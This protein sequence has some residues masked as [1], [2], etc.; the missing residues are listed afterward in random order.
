MPILSLDRFRLLGRVFQDDNMVRYSLP[1][2]STGAHVLS[3]LLWVPS[4]KTSGRTGG[5]IE[6]SIAAYAS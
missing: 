2:V 3:M 5:E 6:A 1:I 4:R